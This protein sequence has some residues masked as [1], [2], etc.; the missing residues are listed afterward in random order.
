VKLGA[1]ALATVG[2]ERN[3]LRAVDLASEMNKSPDTLTKAIAR[4]TKRSSQDASERRALDELD[5][6]IADR[7]RAGSNYGRA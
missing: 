7:G 5:A 2:V 4:G 6:Q 3:E 1:E